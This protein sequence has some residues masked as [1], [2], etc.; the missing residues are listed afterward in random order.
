MTDA[1]F[2]AFL[3][4]DGA[5]SGA[6]YALVALAFVVVYKAS[7]MMNFAVGEW[8]MLASRLVASG[9]P[10]FGLGLGG[11]PGGGCGG[12]VAVAAGVYLLVPRPLL[13]PPPLPPLPALP[14]P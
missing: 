2:L 9:L 5:L 13:A 3:V 1:A 12:L 6:I 7:R 10:T 14:P 4:V 8:A 11:A